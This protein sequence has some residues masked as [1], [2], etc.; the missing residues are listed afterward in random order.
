[1][2]EQIGVIIVYGPEGRF[3]HDTR[4]FLEKLEMRLRSLKREGLIWFQ[5]NWLHGSA[6]RDWEWD[7]EWG[8]YRASDRAKIVLFLLPIDSHFVP[9][10]YVFELERAIERI[11]RHERA[12]VRVIPIFFPGMSEQEWKKIYPREFEPFSRLRALL[13]DAKPIGDRYDEE[14]ALDSIVDSLYEAI[15]ELNP[16]SLAPPPAVP[17]QSASTQQLPFHPSLPSALPL[18][19][20][21]KPLSAQSLNESLS[22]DQV[23]F[24]AFYPA[25]AA[26]EVWNTLLV[27]VSLAS[28][29]SNVQNDA[30]LFRNELGPLPRTSQALSQYLLIRGTN[31][32]I[33][34]ECRG[35]IFNP[36]SVSFQW[37]EEWHRAA[38]R[39]QADMGLVGLASSGEISIYA[40]PL[41]IGM[42]KISLF[43]ND[44]GLLPA[45]AIVEEHSEV[46]GGIYHQLFVSYSHKDTDVVKMCRNI[47]RALGLTVLIDSDNLR[48]GQIW[49][50]ALER[51][52][53]TADVFQLFWSKHAATSRYVHQE[54]EYALRCNKG[55]GFIRPVY[56]KE[57][58]VPPQPELTILHFAYLP[59][60]TFGSLPKEGLPQLLSVIKKGVS[61]TGMVIGFLFALIGILELFLGGQGI[62]SDLWLWDLFFFFGLMIFFIAIIGW[63]PFFILKAGKTRA[64]IGKLIGIIA[65][66]LGGFITVVGMLARSGSSDSAG[67]VAGIISII[68]GI[69]IWWVTRIRIKKKL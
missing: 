68:A 31:L 64:V 13:K 17:E 22:P 63:S 40:G 20:P 56:W 33:V 10:H 14:E 66:L 60:D 61:I 18:P 35:V 48:S 65:I 44:Q 39:F 23:Q 45:G 25:S 58:L 19:A 67:A 34:P 50:N 46:T 42:L 21:P 5:P 49:S 30:S 69:I 15:K 47:Y 36:P 11:E 43:F 29:L 9:F 51:M 3:W 4:W 37:F 6:E 62:F 28:A 53:D 32:T 38:F 7:W 1:M 55:E 8:L 54:W 27:Y 26:V 52:I 2:N 57:P 16:P 24:T 59:P 41:L 12:E